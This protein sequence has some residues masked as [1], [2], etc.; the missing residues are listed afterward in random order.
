MGKVK[1]KS[2]PKK[3]F[4]VF[5][6][7]CKEKFLVKVNLRDYYRKEAK[8]PVSCLLSTL[9]TRDMKD[10][11]EGIII[12][13]SMGGMCV[14][15]YENLSLI[16][17]FSKG[18]ALTFIFSLPPRDERLKV[19]GEI[20]RFSKEENKDYFTIAVRFFSLDKFAEK[21][22]GFFLLP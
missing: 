5:C 4:V 17:Y 16:D 14:R 12:D 6:P 2:P 3:D 15:I 8:I 1:A 18:K 20:V 10:L 22:I 7:H 13:I 21:Q 19:S 9:D 11:G